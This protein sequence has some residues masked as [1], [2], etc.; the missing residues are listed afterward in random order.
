MPH[1]ASECLETINEN[2]NAYW[3]KADKKFLENDNVDIVIQ[4]NGKKKA[5][6]RSLKDITERDFINNIKNSKE[7]DK[8]FKD[9]K[10]IRS[11]FIK[12]RLINLILK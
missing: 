6:V 9:K 11:I 4:I 1:F 5:I 3:P 8:I 7:Y 12:N 2:I 10:I